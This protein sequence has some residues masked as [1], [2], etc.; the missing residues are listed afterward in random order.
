[1]AVKPLKVILGL[2]GACAA[3]CAI[4][5]AAPLFG[6]LAA[7]GV[8]VGF[9]E[10]GGLIAALGVAGVVAFLIWRYWRSRRAAHEGV[11]GACGCAAPANTLQDPE[12]A[13]I[14]CTLPVK[15]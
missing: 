7:G 14:A 9:G 2:A 11:S 8:I 5:L 4:P 6:A 12:P 10:A 1:M 13:T 15:R 3:C